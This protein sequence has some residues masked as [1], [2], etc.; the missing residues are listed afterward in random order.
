VALRKAK[1][2]DL[3]LKY[4]DAAA[5][6]HGTNAILPGMVARGSP[7]R[8]LIKDKQRD[9]G[10]S[11]SPMRPPKRHRQAMLLLRFKSSADNIQ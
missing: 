11:P 10:N 6:Q 7:A 4:S 2:G 9:V 3:V 1:M 8:N 5:K